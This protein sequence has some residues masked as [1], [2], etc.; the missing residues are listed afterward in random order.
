M[1]TTYAVSFGLLAALLAVTPS[2]GQSLEDKVIEARRMQALSQYGME[3][4]ALDS[5]LTGVKAKDRALRKGLG[6]SSAKTLDTTSGGMLDSLLA[7]PLAPGMD[8]T[9]T[10][11]LES[12]WAT[13]S[14]G[15]VTRKFRRKSVP[16][17]YEQRVFQSIDRSAFGGARGAVGRAYVLS[18][19]DQVTVSLWGDKEKEYDLALNPEGKIFLEGVGQ[20][21]LGGLNLNEAQA[22]LKE[23]L[24]RIYSGISRGTAKVDVSVGQAGPIKVFV[25]GEV[26]IPGGYVL[27]GNSSALSALYFARG[28]TDIGTVRSL[29][30]TREGKQYP[31]DLYA[32]LIYGRSLHPEILRDGDIIFSARAEALVEIQGDVGRPATYEMKKGEGI[33]QLLEFAGGLNPTAAAHRMTLL[34]VLKGGRS[35]YVDLATPEDYIS[36][37]AVMELQDGDKLSVDKSTEPTL[38]F[39]TIAGPVKYPGTY[40]AD[41]VSSVKQLIDRAGGVR[42]DAFLGR[43]HIV[44]FLPDGA[45]K[46]F[47]YPLDQSDVDTIRLEPRDNVLLYSLKEMYIPDSVQVEGAVFNPGKYEFRQGMTA[48]DIV[49]QAGGYLP[50]HERG[51]LV[52]FRGGPRDRKVNQ[53][54]LEVEQ[55]LAKTG[56]NFALQPRDIVQVPVDPLWYRKEVV[57]VEGLVLRPG[58]YALLEPGEKLASV[59]ERAGGFKANA[60]VEGGRLFRSKDSVGRVGVDIRKAVAKQRSSANISLVGGDSI[61]IPERQSTVK[62]IGE[63]GFETSVLFLEGAPVGYYIE[64]AGGFTRRSEK[65]RIVVQYANGETGRDGYFNRKPDAG[66]VIYVPQ[67]PEPVAINWFNGINAILGT[68]G[69]AAAVILSI[70]AISQ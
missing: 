56:E 60:Y 39:L 27:T 16:K 53:I 62:V 15:Q 7:G 24:A 4:A 20:V 47:A 8:S 19:G 37:K 35:G 11:G 68:L 22:L 58:K 40:S 50:Q 9:D 23:R 12:Y 14:L 3:E 21:P 26:K 67:G 29:Q 32:N 42:E 54:T 36:G 57:T 46:L 63:V 49:M 31:L 64:R 25:L 66:S 59:I 61:L 52:V 45:S 65:E 5:A 51:R 43:A 38:N 18:P 1:T 33:K 17:R 10:L 13:D 41:G 28:P 2:P 44:R 55:G 70:Q 6:A 48:K 30:L 34:R 69:V